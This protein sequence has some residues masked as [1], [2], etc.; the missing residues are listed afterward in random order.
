MF[1]YLCY[2]IKRTMKNTNLPF[3]I[4][5]FS[6]LILLIVPAL[7]KDGMFMDGEFYALV[8]HNMA[9][10]LGTFW[11]PY[12]SA[13]WFNNGSNI[14]I[15]QPPLVWGIQSLFFKILGNSIYVERIYSFSMALIAAFLITRLWEKLNPIEQTAKLTW[16]PVLLWIITP[17]CAW[18]YQNNV[19]ENTMG[20]FTL[21]AV[22]FTIMG[23]LNEKR[24]YLYFI[25]SGCFIFFA[26]L[27]KGVPGLFPIGALGIYWLITRKI[28]TKKMIIGTAIL[29]LTPVL[30]Y[31]ILFLF[32]QKAN[33]CLTFYFFNKL[34]NRVQ[35]AP[36]VDSRFYIIFRLF[37]EQIPAMLLCL[38]IWGVSKIKSIK[39]SIT[40]DNTKLGIAFLLIGLSGSIPLMLTMVQKGFYFSHSLP[41]FGI[42]FGLLIAPFVTELTLRIN[43]SS[44]SFQ[45]FKYVSI[46]IF[47]VAIL[48]SASQYGKMRKDVAMLKD[49]Y[50][51]GNTVPKNSTISLDPALGSEWSI[52]TGFMRKFNI[53]VDIEHLNL[54]YLKDKSSNTQVPSN[55]TKLDLPTL[56]YDI[57]KENKQ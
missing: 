1:L 16:L 22:L 56:K 8:S 31:T 53:S 32:S 23:V 43:S 39:V 17:V 44:K 2:Q 34:I 52:R 15:E 33:D 14:C 47:I 28:S 45:I 4:L 57:Y 3:K 42:G 5:T 21:S 7:I 13:T 24:S 49:I 48:Y 6:I 41:F 18:S 20:I 12:F 26:S 38:T 11:H 10:G 19:Q 55:Y 25:I 27:S 54:Y 40:P 30:I 35:N 29:I 46:L 51:I 36:T 9:N 37:S 50:T